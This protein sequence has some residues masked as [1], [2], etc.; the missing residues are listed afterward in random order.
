VW[1]ATIKSLFARKLRLLLTALAI[2]LGV[3]F[4][5]GTYVL[6]DTMGK[7]FDD[8]FSTANQNTDVVVRAV[9][10]FQPTQGGPGGS[11]ADER[12]PVPERLRTVVEG[13][14][15]V[16]SVD[17]D[18]TGYAQLVDPPPE[19]SSGRPGHRRSGSRGTPP[20]PRSSS[21]RARRPPDRAR[22]PSTPRRQR[23]ST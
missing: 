7:A 16:A 4:M 15:G 11:G 13:V 6:T 8:L 18:V 14:P 2:V 5:A 22:L 19:R 9:S 3:G 21:A 12:N 20:R 17:G 1:R 10:A 23:S